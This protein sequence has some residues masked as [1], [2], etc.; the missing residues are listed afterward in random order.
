MKQPIRTLLFSAVICGLSAVALAGEATPNVNENGLRKVHDRH[1]D[2]VYV[3]P[4]SRLSDYRTVYIEQPAVQFRKNWARDLNRSHRGTVVYPR[5]E[6]E[7]I[8]DYARLTH[9]VFTEIMEKRGFVIA[10]SRDEGTLVVRPDIVD[11]DIVAPDIPRA[12]RVDV[13][14]ESAGRMTLALTLE[15]GATG[16]PVVQVSDMKEDPRWGYMEWRTRP[17]N[18][19]DARRALKSWANSLADA[20]ED[21]RWTG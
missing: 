12:Q 11:L 21:G 16:K 4:A 8:E 6:Q 3:A 13:Y 5:D 7:L 18:Y 14:S 19:S 17:S 1:L 15:D 2:E 20:I 10:E 9:E